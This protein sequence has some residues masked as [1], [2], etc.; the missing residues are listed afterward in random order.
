MIYT[1]MGIF[2]KKY[3]HFAHCIIKI[4]IFAANHR[5]KRTKIT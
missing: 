1:E 2:Q 3:H 4:T 5:K